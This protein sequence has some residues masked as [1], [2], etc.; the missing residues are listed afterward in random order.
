MK[1]LSVIAV[2]RN[3]NYGVYLNDRLICFFKSI[4]MCPYDI[5]LIL[6]EWNPPANTK[7]FYD[8]YKDILPKNKTIKIITVPNELHE[9][10]KNSNHFNVFEYY[11]KNCG[12]RHVETEYVL[13]TNPDNIFVESVWHDIHNNLTPQTYLRIHRADL[14]HKNIEFK[15]MSVQEI[16]SSLTYFR[17]HEWIPNLSAD[18][19]LLGNYPEEQPIFENASGDFICAKTSECIDFGGFDEASTYSHFDSWF[20]R[21]LWHNQS[22]QIVLKG[23][24]YHIHHQR[25]NIETAEKK[26]LYT[27]L[28]YSEHKNP[29]D[30]GLLNK[31]LIYQTIAKT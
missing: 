17:I 31:T 30:W 21:K 10:I 18:D 16:I 14:L 3:D 1:K 4:E 9:G 12:L 27:S 28:H 26:N 20:V 6:V 5:D 22:N 8:E 2:V 19:I 13:F 23:L 15:N 24:I 7:S 11:A 25:P 29:S